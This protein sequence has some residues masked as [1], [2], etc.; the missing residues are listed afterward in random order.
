MPHDCKWC[1]WIIIRFFRIIWL[2][3]CHV[4]IVF[5]SIIY[6]RTQENQKFFAPHSKLILMFIWIFTFWPEELLV[7]FVDH[8]VF[9]L[10]FECDVVLTS[11]DLHIKVVIWYPSG[12]RKVRVLSVLLLI[13]PNLLWRCFFGI[14]Q[15]AIKTSRFARRHFWV[16]RHENVVRTTVTHSAIAL[17]ATFLFLP[18]FDVICDLLLNRC[19]ATW[20]LFVK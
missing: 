18:H 8:F 19:T 11:N 3:I 1:F 17:C 13:L 20:N 6:T 2:I 12:P 7:V 5:V 4:N 16:A 9:V 15:W 10:K 14:R